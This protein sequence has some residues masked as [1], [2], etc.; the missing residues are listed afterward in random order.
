[1]ENAAESLNF[2]AGERLLVASPFQFEPPPTLPIQTT[3]PTPDLHFRPNRGLEPFVLQWF[4]RL[5][6]MKGLEHPI[7]AA[8]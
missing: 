1:M 2:Q 5:R 8:M 7:S 3:D 4:K 6:E